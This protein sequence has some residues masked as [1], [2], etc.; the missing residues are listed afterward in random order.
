MKLFTDL[1]LQ[2][3]GATMETFN[4]FFERYKEELVEKQ[5]Y[6]KIK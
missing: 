6:Q 2:L 3:E 1:I 5:N 4:D